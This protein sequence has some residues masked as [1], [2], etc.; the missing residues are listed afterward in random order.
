MTLSI[1]REDLPPPPRAVGGDPSREE[2]I[3]RRTWVPGEA[4]IWALILTDLC[5][6]TVYFIVVMFEWN[7]HQAEFAAGRESIKLSLG[8]LNTCFLLTA[9]L[10]VA[11][12][13]QTLRVGRVELTR[14]L[15]TVSGVCGAA[16]VVNKYFEWSDK[17]SHDHT[18]QTSIF[19]Q[20]YFVITGLHLLHVLIAMTLLRFMRVRAGQV[21]GTPTPQQSRFVEN[22]A[23][24]WH[25]VDLLWLVILALFYLMG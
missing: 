18:P 5:V 9:S 19:F 6:F 23:S 8:I 16:F 17:V 20:L 10:F 21:V 25:M 13:V 24:Y 22:C 15:F 12:G 1:D 2:L 14:R 7:Q 3:A 4:G 11:L